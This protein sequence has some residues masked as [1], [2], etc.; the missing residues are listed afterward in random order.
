MYGTPFY[1]T[2]R[3]SYSPSKTVRF[4]LAHPV[5]PRLSVRVRE[6]GLGFVRSLTVLHVT[7]WV[8][9]RKV[10]HNIFRSF[11]CYLQDGPAYN[12]SGYT[13]DRQA[14]N[15]SLKFIHRLISHMIWGRPGGLLQSSGG[16]QLAV[17]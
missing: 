4:F 2:H 9:R 6:L 15:I 8:T 13:Q 14:Y 3:K 1:V 11:F 7:I 5:C 16:Q 10:L 17:S 12:P